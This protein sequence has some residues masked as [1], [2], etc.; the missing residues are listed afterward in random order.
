M[1]EKKYTDEQVRT[2]GTVEDL[3]IVAD[4]MAMLNIP[5]DKLLGISDD[6]NLVIKEDCNDDCNNCKTCSG[7]DKSQKEYETTEKDVK[8][9]GLLWQSDFD[10]ETLPNSVSKEVN[11][12]VDDNRCNNINV[13]DHL[14]NAI[15]DINY[16]KQQII[17]KAV[18]DILEL[19]SA[20][21]TGIIDTMLEYNMRMNICNTIDMCHLINDTANK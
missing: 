13:C 16:K 15:D 17:T 5:K 11:A 3:I 20:M 18:K 2:I 1:K 14:I 7:A 6:G 12:I 4:T 19:D 9:R 8:R 21:C 10:T